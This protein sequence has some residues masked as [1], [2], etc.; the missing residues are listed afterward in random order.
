MFF[1]RQQIAGTECTQGR[2]KEGKEG[3]LKSRFRS[4]RGKGRGGEKIGL[5]LCTTPLGVSINPCQL[6]SMLQRTVQ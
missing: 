1:D 2:E 3:I 5:S 6:S 4:G